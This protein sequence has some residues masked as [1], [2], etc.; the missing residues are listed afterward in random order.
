MKKTLGFFVMLAIMLTGCSN[1]SEKTLNGTGTI[2]FD[3]PDS[4][5]DPDGSRTH[6][7]RR[8]RAAL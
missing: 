3:V 7:L 6:D 8:D 2:R 1:E 5:Y 4:V